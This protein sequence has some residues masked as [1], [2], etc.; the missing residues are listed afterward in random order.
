VTNTTPFDAIPNCDTAEFVAT[1]SLAANGVSIVTTDGEAGTAGL[2][3]SSMVSVCAEPALMLA[4]VNA[5]NEFCRIADANQA[6]AIN[7][8]AADQQAVSNVF[9]G[10]GDDPKANRF[11]TGEWSMRETGSPILA[12]A[13]VS[14]DCAL[15]EARTHGTHK[16]YIGRVLSA[17]SRDT[18]PL[19]YSRRGYVSVA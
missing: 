4:C 15:V 12:D 13:L 17:Q 10:F 18:A 16:I 1:L 9:A 14:L 8:L 3:V 7:L 6:F 19:V 11:D 5:D 2:T